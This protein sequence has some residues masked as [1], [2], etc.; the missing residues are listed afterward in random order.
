MLSPWFDVDA[1]FAELNALLGSPLRASESG[2][3]GFV[4]E[5]DGTIVWTGDLPGLTRDDVSVSIDDGVLTVQATRRDAKAPEG[6]TP[7]YTERRAY[8]FTRTLR[9]SDAVDVDGITAQFEDGTL[10]LRLPTRPATQP[11]RIEVQR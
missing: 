5:Q 11:R 6:F 1:A 2:P 8:T 10:T 9:V 7:R 3:T 4:R